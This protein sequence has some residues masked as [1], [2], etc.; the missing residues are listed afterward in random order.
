MDDRKMC[1]ATCGLDGKSLPT[2][3]LSNSCF[4]IGNFCAAEFLKLS[5]QTCIKQNAA[6]FTRRATP[7]VEFLV[8]IGEGNTAS[9]V[10][11]QAAFDELLLIGDKG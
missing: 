10:M 6:P 2:Q 7:H 11:S 8:S 4:V 5:I 1:L 9:I 3:K